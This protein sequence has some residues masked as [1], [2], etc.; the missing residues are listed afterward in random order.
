MATHF[1][2][3]R[4]CE[5]DSPDRP[6]FKYGVRHYCHAECGFKRWGNEFMTKIPAHQIGRIPYRLILNDPERRA[7]A[8]K[9]CP[10]ISSAMEP[11]RAD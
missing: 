11:L 6:M 10:L 2:T 3:C 1:S 4:F 5:D 7:L 9:L 8:S